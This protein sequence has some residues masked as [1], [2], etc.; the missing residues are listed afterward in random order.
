MN[1]YT[2]VIGGFAALILA[3]LAFIFLFRT[4]DEK[5]IEKLLE[6][7]LAAAEAGD[8]EG[9][10]AL[11]SPDYRNGE[12]TRDTIVRRIRQAVSQ[13]ITP[14]RMEGAAIQV[15][16]D[17]AE[18]SVKVVVGALQ[19]RREFGLRLKLRK[20]NGEWKV[21]SADERGY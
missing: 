9:V 20:E 5:A 1:F 21:I 13:R 11:I 4:T 14:A 7:G 16:G 3:A 19:L 15:S 12:E 6:K 10:I 18:A 2:K 8:T 17:E